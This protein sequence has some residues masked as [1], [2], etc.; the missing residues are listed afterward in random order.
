[1]SDQIDVAVDGG[2]LAAFRLAAAVPDGERVL[3]IHGITSSSRTW[4]AT[5]RALGDRAG[6]A[7]VDLGPQRR[8]AAAVRPRRAR[9]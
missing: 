4:L 1:V 8:A 2:S 5:A 7:A 9:A 6:L 3:A